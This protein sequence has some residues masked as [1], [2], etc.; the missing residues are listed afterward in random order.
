MSLSRDLGFNMTQVGAWIAFLGM[1]EPEW[2]SCGTDVPYATVC[3]SYGGLD[4]FRVVLKVEN[5][6]ADLQQVSWY[7]LKSL[8]QNAR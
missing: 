2:Y 6:A 3:L 1:A 5:G 4:I 7:R 8:K